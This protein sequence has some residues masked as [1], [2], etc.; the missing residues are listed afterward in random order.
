MPAYNQTTISILATPDFSRIPSGVPWAMDTMS[1]AHHLGL[2]NRTLLGL[3]INRE[4]HYQSFFIKKKSGG[5]RTI[6]APSPRLKFAQARLLKRFFTNIEYPAHIAAYVEGRPTR[7]SAEFHT[8]KKVVI[9]ID[10]KDF[11]TSTRRAWVRRVMQGYFGFPFEVASAIADIVSVPVMT[12]KGRRYVVPQGA[13][14]S[15]AVCNWVAHVRID[16]PVLAL[17]EKWGIVYTRYADDLAFSTEKEMTKTEVNRFIRQVIKIIQKSGYE[18]NAKKLRVTRPGR[19]QRLL[20]MTV[21]EKPNIIRQQYRALR[22]RIHNC[23]YQGFDQVATTMGLPNGDA[24]MSQLRG[25]ISYYAMI[26]ADKAQKLNNQLLD[27]VAHHGQI[28][29]PLSC[30]PDQKPDDQPQG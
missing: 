24:L 7:Y 26:N 6:H 19:Q 14:T 16:L 20:G 22:A 4:K 28:L 18:I 23:K 2:R 10:L 29:Q 1:L 8:K 9:V 13:P 11:F 15:G 21:N 17:C 25:K 3:I 30:D 12:P 27:A 5:S